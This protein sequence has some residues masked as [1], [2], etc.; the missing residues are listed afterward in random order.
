MT[1]NLSNTSVLVVGGC[2]FLGHHIVSQLLEVHAQVSVLEFK[3]DR[4]RIPSV[5][6]HNAD[7]T[8]KSD[9]EEVLACVRPRVIIPTASPTALSS[10]AALYHRVNIKG[11]RNL[12]ECARSLD[13]VKAFV[14][15]SSGFLVHDTVRDLINADQTFSV[16]YIPDQ[17]QVYSHTKAL[18][19][20][21]VLA[22]NDPKA[23]MLTT[24]LRPVGIF[25]EGDLVALQTM[26]ENAES[27]K[28][29]VQFGSGDNLCDWTYVGN[30]ARAH[31]LAVEGLWNE[32]SSSHTG[33]SSV[34]LTMV[35]IAEW[36]VWTTSLGKQKSTMALGGI[37]YS[38][39]TRTYRIEKAKAR[40]GYEA[41]V[42][43]KEG[44]QRSVGWWLA[45][46]KE[47][48]Q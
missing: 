38:C 19:D 35:M 23:G 17:K 29:K 27:G 28:N 11:T 4:N 6:Y 48:S 5:E 12:L 34:G 39:L 1:S 10:D 41:T 26:I 45:N 20:D 33:S 47:K 24:S 21:L 44:I 15:T 9:V 18:T 13:T 25:G 31:L 40:L 30:A 42:T 7:I 14:Y 2:G 37:R 32:V 43:I 36:I 8:V 22:S 46:R 16:L 3:L